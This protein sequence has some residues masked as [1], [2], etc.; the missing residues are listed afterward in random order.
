MATQQPG[1]DD[2]YKKMFV[3]LG[4]DWD[5]LNPQQMQTALTQLGTALKNF[6]ESPEYKNSFFGTMPKLGDMIRSLEPDVM[7]STRHLMAFGAASKTGLDGGQFYSSL[8]LF[9]KGLSTIT[10]FLTGA[11]KQGLITGKIFMWLGAKATLGI[12][13]LTD[14]S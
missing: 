12:S 6:S 14:V 11:G 2:A 7:R 10:S 8:G 9:G 5:K 13:L 3:R 4:F 1:P